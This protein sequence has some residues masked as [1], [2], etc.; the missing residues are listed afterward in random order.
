MAARRI[1]RLRVVGGYLWRV[2][3]ASVGMGLFVLAAQRWLP[4]SALGLAA[5]I[6]LAVIVY[7]V[8]I[9][10]IGGIVP[11]E[12]RALKARLKGFF[13]RFRAHAFVRNG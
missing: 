7:T 12:K 11:E 10:A 8:L 6:A 9:L 3:L 1:V 4:P 5:T 2:G 13:V